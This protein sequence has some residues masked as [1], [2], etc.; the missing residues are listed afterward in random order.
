[1][2]T[3][4]NNFLKAVFY[5]ALT[6][7]GI[8]GGHLLGQ[9]LGKKVD[10]ETLTM[11]GA[12]Y[13]YNWSGIATPSYDTAGPFTFNG[14]NPNDISSWVWCIESTIPTY[15]GRRYNGQDIFQANFAVRVRGGSATAGVT[16]MD[17]LI[18]ATMGYVA[19]RMPDDQLATL[20]SDRQD[21]LNALRDLRRV[22]S[23]EV[24]FTYV[25]V[26]YWRISDPNIRDKTITQFT[27]APLQN[28][29]AILNRLYGLR[30]AM[31]AKLQSG[32]LNYEGGAR[33]WSTPQ[34]DQ[35]IVTG[36]AGRVIVKSNG[37]LKVTKEISQLKSE[38]R[39]NV[40]PNYDLTGI[41]VGVYSNE[42]ATDL[43]STL[44]IG[45]NG[46][47]SVVELAP[48]VYYLY[49]LDKDGN[50][51]KSD[52]QEIFA[53]NRG[54]VSGKSTQGQYYARVEVTTNHTQQAPAIATFRNEPKLVN[55]DIK[56]VSE[57]EN[58]IPFSD[59]HLVTGAE[60][61]LYKDEQ[62]NDPV[63]RNGQPVVAIIGAD[64]IGQFRD[65]EPNIYYVKETKVPR[66]RGRSIY[67]LDEKAYRV[68]LR[69]LQNARET[70]EQNATDGVTK[71][72]YFGEGVGIVKSNEAVDP[73]EGYLKIRKV[74]SDTNTNVAQGQ[75]TLEGA[76]FEIQI[77]EPKTLGNA[78]IKGATALYKT[79]AAGEI[80]IRD[81]SRYISSDNEALMKVL[82]D[83]YASKGY[84]PPYD[85]RV[86]EIE[87]PNGYK[88]PADVNRTKDFSIIEQNTQ[89]F[90]GT[91]EDLPFQEDDLELHLFKRQRVDNTTLFGLSPMQPAEDLA[92]A[93][94]TFTI[95]NKTTGYKYENVQSD[96]NGRILLHGIADGN[97]ELREVNAGPKYSLNNQVITFTVAKV[98]G[99]HKMTVSSTSAHNDQNAPYTIQTAE[100][101]DIHITY[102]NTPKEFEIDLVKS[103]E[104]GKR[105]KGAKFK[106]TRIKDDGTAEVLGEVKTDDNGNIDFDASLGHKFVIGDLYEIEEV[107]AP[108]GY[109]LP[110][111]RVRIQFRANAIP[112]K[113]QYSLN[114]RTITVD[115]YIASNTAEVVSEWKTLSQKNTPDGGVKFDAMEASGEMRVSLDMVNNT[116][117]KLP[118][119]GSSLNMIVLIVGAVMLVGGLGYTAY[120]RRQDS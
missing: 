72:Y 109:K 35:R 73:Q 18:M 101:G 37:Y 66:V 70:Q 33:V 11:G 49:E 12:E 93:G 24:K 100:N 50:P 91:Y 108:V 41:R 54:Y 120:S 71:E 114:Y 17:K 6:A 13:H 103:N 40:R 115:K 97:Y 81:R 110:Q 78:N 46:E 96:Q 92:I 116:W 74:D 87:A 82:F 105:L 113:D 89:Y 106:L 52:A 98:D 2:K 23:N 68:D 10:A 14:G 63:T 75:G 1:M 83:N 95:T 20:F 16:H 76:V 59:T 43:K 53:E 34:G 102:D 3:K 5:G 39:T 88:L 94:S 27:Y 48:G 56:K 62:G 28:N 51:I 84:W 31:E 79:N 77:F 29:I 47:S 107:E 104:K 117:Q 15:T 65:L 80:D 60:Y 64:G 9:G 99:S 58:L 69:N 22:P 67:R 19:L 55:F 42:A 119:T 36:A 4:Y 85:Y 45:S 7:L 57:V 32:D 61:T 30:A 38:F 90:E 111:N 112:V 26:L 25:Q 118:K 44:T 86:T 21:I 8:F